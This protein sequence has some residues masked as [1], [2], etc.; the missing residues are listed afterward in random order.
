MVAW[1]TLGGHAP[2]AVSGCDDWRAL[3]LKLYES[4]V[5]QNTP[6]PHHLVCLLIKDTGLWFLQSPPLRPHT[7]T[8]ISATHAKMH[9]RWKCTCDT[10][11]L[12]QG[13]WLC[14]CLRVLVSDCVRACGWVGIDCVIIAAA[15]SASLEADPPPPSYNLWPSPPPCHI[16]GWWSRWWRCSTQSRSATHVRRYG[17][18]SQVNS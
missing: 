14:V 4:S 6:R 1:S 18:A 5:P 12:L 3:F 10:L 11:V 2:L 7:H 15:T 16:M 9:T 8:R 17:T 13:L